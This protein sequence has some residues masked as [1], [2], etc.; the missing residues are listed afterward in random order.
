MEGTSD[1]LML[2]FFRAISEPAKVEDVAAA[3]RP[4]HTVTPG[5]ELSSQVDDD[6]ISS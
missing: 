2:P 5:A 4:M 3:M 6:T 1:S